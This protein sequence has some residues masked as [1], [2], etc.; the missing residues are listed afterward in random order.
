MF[1]SRIREKGGGQNC[2]RV[3]EFTLIVLSIQG[4]GIQRKEHKSPVKT[5]ENI[6][7]KHEGKH[8]IRDAFWTLTL[9]NLDSG[10]NVKRSTEAGRHR[11]IQA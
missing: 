5:E 9:K 11:H 10:D 2:S 8:C 1:S 4:C 6:I 3:A 7:I